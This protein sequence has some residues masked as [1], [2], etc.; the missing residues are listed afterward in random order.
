MTLDDKIYYELR[1]RKPKGMNSRKRM[2]LHK[3]M[4]LHAKG[5]GYKYFL[6]PKAAMRW[7]DSLPTSKTFKNHWCVGEWSYL[8]FNLSDGT[9]S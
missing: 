4:R 2:G 3:R 1:L 5:S 7:L 6:S 8:H 9:I